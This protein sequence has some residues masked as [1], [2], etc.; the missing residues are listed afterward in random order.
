MGFS[1][2]KIRHQDLYIYYISRHFGLVKK[3]KLRET[4]HKG[5]NSAVQSSQ[6][7]W[8]GQ[9][10]KSV[11]DKFKFTLVYSDTEQVIVHKRFLFFTIL[12]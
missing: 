3:G 2:L 6:L 10:K 7:N 1:L 5:I 8:T 4:R 12:A 9:Y 11:Q